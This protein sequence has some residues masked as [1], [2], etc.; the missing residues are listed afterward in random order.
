MS[1]LPNTLRFSRHAVYERKQAHQLGGLLFCH[2]TF[3]QTMCDL[4]RIAMQEPFGTPDCVDGSTEPAAFIQRVQDQ[5]FEHCMAICALFE[6]AMKHGHSALADTWLSVVAHDSAKVIIQYVSKGMG[7]SGTKGE[8][9]KANAIFA[10][11][12]NI[13][14]LHTMIPLHS[15]AQSLVR[16]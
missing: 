16:S 6:E 5:R 1:K 3:H 12:S 9:F 15:I 4:M 14:A 8:A 2:V 7:S 11:H 10:V 13:R